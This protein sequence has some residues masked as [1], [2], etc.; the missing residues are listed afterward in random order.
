[1]EPE[2]PAGSE[3]A[4]L[5]GSVRCPD[6]RRTPGRL[7]DLGDSIRKDGLKHPIA[8]WKDGTLISGMRRHRAYL[9]LGY[10][11]IPA[12]FVETI[13]D[14]AKRLLIDNQDDFLAVPMKRVEICRLW[15]VLRRLD[16]PAAAR[17]ID[18]ARRRG[19]ELRRQTQAGERPPGRVGNRS[20]DY[21]LSVLCE[22]FGLS[23]SAANRL[24]GVY[25]AAY[26]SQFVEAEERLTAQAIMSAIETGESSISAGYSRI[27][28]GRRAPARPR[29]AQP[30][31]S[32]PPGRQLT[33][34]EKSL[35]QMEGLLAG[36]AELGP[37][38]SALTWEQIRPI[39]ARLSAVRRD[40]EKMI[41]QMKGTSRP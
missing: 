14:A 28:A 11:H 24:W 27:T 41:K 2:T 16:K 37:P 33:V 8:V 31:L 39:H 26:G 10:K 15:E 20:D 1:M 7:A 29:A 21:V 19:V 35:P 17:R 13:E 40:L 22:P 6:V 34:W 4:I 5:T 36:L 25:V 38:N 9:M 30:A 12:I 3:I 18:A 23:E 32:A